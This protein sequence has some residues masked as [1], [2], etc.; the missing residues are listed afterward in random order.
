MGTRGVSTAG[1][2]DR[3]V[4]QARATPAALLEVAAP[5]R[6]VLRSLRA[7]FEQTSLAAQHF[8]RTCADALRKRKNPP[9]LDGTEQAL[10]KYTATIEG[11]RREGV[12][13]TLPVESI[14]RLHALGFTLEQLRRDL[15]D[16]HQMRPRGEIVQNRTL[17][18]VRL[19]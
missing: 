13:R 7:S 3:P 9:A 14:S 17:V 10:A 5:G 2:G 18:E 19:V 1:I 11:L 16:S 8:L 12:I 6:L 4:L 15:E